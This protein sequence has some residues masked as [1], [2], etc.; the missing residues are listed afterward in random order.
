MRWWC[1]VVWQ[2]ARGQGAGGSHGVLFCLKP[3]HASLIACLSQSF[4][5]VPPPPTAE[6]FVEAVD[7]QAPGVIQRHEFRDLIL[8]M[9]A[10]DLHSRRAQHELEQRGDWSASSWEQEEESVT[11]LKSWTDSLMVQRRRE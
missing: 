11:R 3:L 2:G 4:P 7:L 10:A 8:H 1:V 5:P 9:A 6:L